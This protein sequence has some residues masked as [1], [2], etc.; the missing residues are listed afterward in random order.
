MYQSSDPRHADRTTTSRRCPTYSLRSCGRAESANPS[1]RCPANPRAC[2]EELCRQLCVVPKL[3]P[4]KPPCHWDERCLAGSKQTS[5]AKRSVKI[6]NT[7]SPEPD[8]SRR[9]NWHRTTCKNNNTTSWLLEQLMRVGLGSLIHTWK[10]RS[11]P[12]SLQKPPLGLSKRVTAKRKIR[13]TYRS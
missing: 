10:I 2:I 9:A 13:I 12:S 11:Y 8:V 6:E 7:S 5:D 1:A 3:L 4:S